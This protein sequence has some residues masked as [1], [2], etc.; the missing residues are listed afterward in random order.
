MSMTHSAVSRIFIVFVLRAFALWEN[1]FRMHS[2]KKPRTKIPTR[3]LI[4]IVDLI[5]VSGSIHNQDF[6]KSSQQ[7]LVLGSWFCAR[8]HSERISSECRFPL[9]TSPNCNALPQCHIRAQC[10][11]HPLLSAL[12]HGVSL[13]RLQCDGQGCDDIDSSRPTAGVWHQYHCHPPIH[14][15]AAGENRS[16]NPPSPRKPPPTW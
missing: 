14:K 12:G 1:A 15:S 7:L 10:S 6:H 16:R 13:Y 3:V 8:M 2:S 9:S 4:R 5:G 11:M